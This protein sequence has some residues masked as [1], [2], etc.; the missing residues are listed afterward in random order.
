MSTTY[1]ITNIND[2]YTA[3]GDSQLPTPVYT[4]YL[5]TTN[6]TFT[7]TNP[8]FLT[9]TTTPSGSNGTVDTDYLYI[10]AGQNF[11]GH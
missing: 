7:S 2:W 4:T 6:L 1:S 3:I 5:L 8:P 9:S 10:S 11:N